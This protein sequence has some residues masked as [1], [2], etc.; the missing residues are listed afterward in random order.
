M[1]IGRLALTIITK[2]PQWNALI[3]NENSKTYADL[4]YKRWQQRF[5]ISTKSNYRD[6]SGR[7]ALTVKITGATMIIEH[8]KAY[9]CWVVRKGGT[10]KHIAEEKISQLWIASDIKP[11]LQ[12]TQI[13]CS[14]LGVQTPKGIPLKA[15]HNTNGKMVSVLKT[16]SVKERKTSASNFDPLPGYRKVNDEI[17]LLMG[18]SSHE[19]MGDWLDLQ[20]SKAK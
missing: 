2:A 7:L 1:H 18:Q 6:Q 12:I 14:H 13:F 15:S 19:A 17:E 10:N 16:L 3:F 9:Q 4:P 11:P 5:S 20:G 8:H